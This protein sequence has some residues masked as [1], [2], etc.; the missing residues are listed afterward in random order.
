MRNNL[1]TKEHLMGGRILLGAALLLG[2]LGNLCETR[3]GVSNSL[4]DVSAD[5]TLI[6]CS[7]RD[8]GTVTIIDRSGR[9]VLHEIPVGAKPEG[10]SFLGQSHQVAVAVYADDRVVW[11]DADQGTR[12]AETSLFD[13]PY[14]VVGNMAGTRLYVTQEYPGTV[15]EIDAQSREV[16]REFPVGSLPR[17]IALD[18][19]HQRLYVTEYLT[20]A[21]VAV[22]LETGKVVDRWQGPSSENLARQLVLH[23]TRPKAYVPHI[24]S[25]VNVHQG[26]GSVLP[27]VSVADLD[28]QEERRRKTLPMDSFVGA[29]VVANPWESAISP[30]GKILVSVFAGTD[31]AFVAEVL[32]D[33][34]RE[35]SF[36]RVLRLGHNPRA[37]KFSPDGSECY[38]YNALD[39]DLL[40]YDTESFNRQGHVRV[41]QSSLSEEQ[42][43]GKRLFYSALEPMVGRRWISCASCHPD[44]DPDGRTWQNPEGLRNT[45]TLFG[46]AW[47]HPIHWSADRDE[48]QDFEHTI[49]G[50]LMQGQ[51]LI[52]GVVHDS[53][54]TPNSGRSADL[55]ALAVYSNSHK[56]TLSPHGRGGLSAAAQRGRELFHS[57]EAR[58]VECHSGPYFTD[59]RPEKPFRLHDVGTGTED[60][61][62]K[63]GPRYDT[64]SLLGIYRSAPYLHHGKAA[65][66]EDVLTRFNRDDQHGKTSQLN[67]DQISDLV[68]FL[69]A[70]PFEDPELSAKGAKLTKVEK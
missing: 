12:L 47:T 32:D 6:A 52:R 3:A 70:L 19:A 35:L 64:P 20:A 25:R 10:V 49:R 26:E 14:G 68:Q 4:L 33:N 43:L 42:L 24:R 51:G 38:I 69:K 41:C 31:D 44:G 23:P 54:G 9:K 40:I 30:D 29:F 57:A 2:L 18:E 15:A 46:M 21:I 50:P 8:N 56:F 5:G 45:M 39:F 63:M 60:A 34:Y 36:R 61:T 37:V 59:S 58:C 16:L 7:N 11:L 22:D 62:E 17:G 1:G 65:T 66:L 48:V 67:P 13:E 28:S 55:D 27:F 53:L